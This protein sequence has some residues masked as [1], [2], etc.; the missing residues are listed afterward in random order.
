MMF[1]SV[2]LLTA[3]LLAFAGNAQAAA[4]NAV[5]RC[6][7]G[8][9]AL[10][11]LPGLPADVKGKGPEAARTEEPLTQLRTIALEAQARSADVQAAQFTAQAA[12]H[13]IDETRAQG[14]PQIGMG[15]NA[16]AIASR[17]SGAGSSSTTGGTGGLSLSLSMPLYDG[18]RLQYMTE[19][20]TLLADASRQQ[21]GIARERIV[22][23][24]IN[25]ALDR[26]RYRLQAQIRQQQLRKVSC[27]VTA[28][29]QIVAEDRGRT[30]ELVQAR[31]TQL[32]TEIMR[33]QAISQ[34]RQIDVHLRQLV[35]ENIAP[36]TGIGLPLFNV[37]PLDQV[38]REAKD[39]REV[40]S[41]RAQADALGSYAKSVNAGQKPQ[42]SWNV[43]GTSG[44]A[45]GSGN[46]TEVRA[47][48]ALSYSIFNGHGGDAQTA[49]A[50]RRADAMR[51][52]L[53]GLLIA[54]VAGARELHDLATSSF[55]RAKSYAQMLRDADKLRDFTV[56]Q[57]SQLGR[58]S[59]FDVISTESEYYNARVDYINSLYTG[60]QATA[61]L[62]SLGSGLADW[63]TPE[64]A[65]VR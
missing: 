41:L 49:A 50:Q 44:R 8:A 47:G 21:V 23:E 62:R 48:V 27:L 12:R 11:P 4:I 5:M 25:T 65:P 64:T 20:R 1:R 34:I 53:E 15:A 60:F 24:A 22:L 32:Q 63:L 45:P 13:D 51:Q 10:S 36:W 26:N 16:A 6:N 33:D 3:L 30:S 14:L 61:E 37:P 43:G 39:A 38:V 54:R 57:W 52:Q 42:L 40:Q 46:T 29:E 59:L 28:L 18:G 19:Y 58:R 56:E 7:D 55:D 2:P 17:N 9:E 31:K 35:G